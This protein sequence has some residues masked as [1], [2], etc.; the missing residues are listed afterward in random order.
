MANQF[1]KH[2]VSRWIAESELG[3]VTAWSRSFSAVLRPLGLPEVS[4]SY[5]DTRVMQLWR[6]E[7]NSE[8]VVVSMGASVQGAYRTKLTVTQTQ[9]FVKGVLPATAG[10]FGLSD[11]VQ[12]K[13]REKFFAFID[14]AVPNAPQSVSFEV[15][16]AHLERVIQSQPELQMVKGMIGFAHANAAIQSICTG[17]APLEY[18]LK[19]R[20]LLARMHF[21]ESKMTASDRQFFS[22]ENVSVVDARNSDVVSTMHLYAWANG[23]RFSKLT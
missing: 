23:L 21:H 17:D 11:V 5:G 15:F 6:R 16:F 10:S 20:S 7:S 19:A 12:T 18:A 22:K 9:V 1:E 4:V 13:L 3:R 2:S 8:L 14:A